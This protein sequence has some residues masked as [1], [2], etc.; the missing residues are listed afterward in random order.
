[1]PHAARA[2]RM[3]DGDGAPAG[4]VALQV[5]VELL[6]PHERDRRRTPRCTPWRRS[7]RST[8]RCARAAARHGIRRRQHEHRIVG[9][10]REVQEAR[11]DRQAEALGGRAVGD[12]HRGGAV[13]HLRRVAGGDV[14]RGLLVRHPRRR[15]RGE[16]LHRAAAADALVGHEHVVGEVA[17]LVL[18]RHRHDLASRS[19]RCRC[20]P[21]RGGG[22]RAR[23]RP[24]PRGDAELVGEDLRDLELDAERVVG[25]AQERGAERADAAARVRRHR[26]PGH[27]LDAARDGEVVAPAITPWATKC[28]ACCDDPHWRS[29]VVAGTCRRQTG[30]RPRRCESRCSPARR[31]G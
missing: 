3:A 31:P 2:E 9:Q 28:I 1:M 5:G 13:A 11:P 10:H 23:R 6:G 19:G 14:G 15:Q 17:V 7:R 21:R 25:V 22:S 24:S 26:R 29:T 30:R 12:E 4:V 27:R 16:R 8:G 20:S 18:D